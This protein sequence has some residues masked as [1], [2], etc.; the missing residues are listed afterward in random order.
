M[1][2]FSSGSPVSASDVSKAIFDIKA[3]DKKNNIYTPMLSISGKNSPSFVSLDSITSPKISSGGFAD[4]SST[5]GSEGI[6][7]GSSTG[8]SGFL[9]ETFNK[10][11]TDHVSGAMADYVPLQ[12]KGKTDEKTVIEDVEYEVD[13]I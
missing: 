1:R 11:N 5:S 2:F 12:S 7:F 6:K 9:F 3:A 8:G 4:S 10:I 13:E